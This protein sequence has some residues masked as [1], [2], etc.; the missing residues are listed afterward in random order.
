M[1]E[2]VHVY[3][4]CYCTVIVHY[5]IIFNFL[6]PQNWS[7]P[8]VQPNL[9]PRVT[10]VSLNKVPS[11]FAPPTEA[12]PSETSAPLGESSSDRVDES[13]RMEVEEGES[14]EGMED[15]SP[16][17]DL[18]LSFSASVKV[19]IPYILVVKHMC[20]LRY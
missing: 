16:E 17:D 14:E 11:V 2:Y 13:E 5:D 10:P 1:Y 8:G 19:L 12:T 18:E 3:S 20:L 9:I 7:L 4:S 15:D 6:S